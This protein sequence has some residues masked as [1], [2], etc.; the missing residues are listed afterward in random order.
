MIL[1]E[2]KTDF[3]EYLLEEAQILF[4]E[5]NSLNQAILYS[6]LSPG[7]RIRPLLCMGFS[8]GFKG[9]KEVALACALGVEMIHAYSLIHDDLPAMDN[10][11]FRRGKLTNHKVFGEAMA[12]LAGDSL[13]NLAPQFLLK[14][15]QQHNFNPEL[16]LKLVGELLIS[17]GHEGMVKGQ[18]LDMHYESAELNGLSQE[19]LDQILRQIHQLKTG[20]IISWSCLAGLYSLGNSKVTE[21]Y[22]SKVLSLGQD[23]GLLFQMVDDILDVTATLTDLGKTPG[24][25]QK[26]GKLTYTNLYGLER[27]KSMARDLAQT[28]QKD[29]KTWEAQGDW[30]II[31][32]IVENLKSKID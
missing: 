14:K 5:K 17:S 13:L 23:I 24:K 11:D 30:S 12:I 25:D 31:Q 8:Q 1:E 9:S 26:T 2:Y 6:L 7:K 22:A 21:L 20:A 3:D 27:A 18:A 29:L 15:L 19:E 10:D 4:K 16:S 32:R 28:I